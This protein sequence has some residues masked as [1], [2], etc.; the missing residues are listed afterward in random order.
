MHIIAISTSGRLNGNT[1]R[2]L[3]VMLDKLA[4]LGATTEFIWTGNKDIQYCKACEY[5]MKDDKC[6]IQDDYEEIRQ[7]MLNADGVI[8]GTPN[9]GFQMSGQLKAIY[10][11][12]HSLLYY[13]RRL[14]GKYAVGVC[15]GGHSYMTGK[16]AKTVAQGIWLCGGY[17]AGYLGAASVNRDELALQNEEQI[18]KKAGYLAEKLYSAILNKK[19]FRWQHFIRRQFLYPQVVKMVENNKSKYQFLYEYYK[20]KGYL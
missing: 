4:S 10:D 18:I 8:L 12:S 3:K 11:R 17:Y 19:K 1:S 6:I 7:K 9:Y 5:C 20:S 13:T 15:V 16:I 14:V 2:V